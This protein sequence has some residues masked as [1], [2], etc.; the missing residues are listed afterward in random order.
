MS[1]RFPSPING[2]SFK[3]KYLLSLKVPLRNC[4]RPLKAGLVL[5]LASSSEINL[6]FGEQSFRPLK[7]GLVLNPFLRSRR[8][9]KKSCCFRP[10]K[11]GLVLNLF[12]EIKGADIHDLVSVP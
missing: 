9:F 10:L 3:Q 2:V 7:A 1:L 12:K 6:R 8:R 4:F 5:N 11:A